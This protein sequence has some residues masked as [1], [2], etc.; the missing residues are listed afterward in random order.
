MTVLPTE[1]C[2]V[3]STNPLPI[4]I[5]FLNIL[6]SSLVAFVTIGFSLFLINDN[7]LFII[8]APRANVVEPPTPLPF[9]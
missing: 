1:L 2:S 5:F 8:D 7:V 9:F 3:T 6:S 4:L